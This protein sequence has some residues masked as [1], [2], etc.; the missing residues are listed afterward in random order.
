MWMNKNLVVQAAKGLALFSDSY[1]YKEYFDMTEKEIKQMKDE[2]QEQQA[3][4]MEQQMQQQAAMQPPMPGGA[5]PPPGAAGGEMPPD[6]SMPPNGIEGQENMP[7]TS[8][9][10]ESL[11]LLQDIKNQNILNENVGKALVFDRIIKK[12]NTK[13]KNIDK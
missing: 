8:P 11:D 2:L 12:Y 9:P 10:Q 4:M 5:P 7:P 3:Q 1:I 6:G 13:L